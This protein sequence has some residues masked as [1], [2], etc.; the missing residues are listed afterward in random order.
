[1]SPLIERFDGFMSLLVMA[2]LWPVLRRLSKFNSSNPVERRLRGILLAAFVHFLVRIPHLAFNIEQFG[3]LAYATAVWL[4]FQIFLFFET[5]LR[6]HMPLM[7]KIWMVVGSLFWLIASLLGRVD[8]SL[9]AIRFLGIYF[10]ISQGWTLLVCLL[11]RRADY[12]V[13]E[14]RFIDLSMVSLVL[15]GPFLLTDTALA[16]SWGLPRLGAISVLVFTYVS[17]YSDSVLQRKMVT[18]RRLGSS[19]LQALFLA[20]MVSLLFPHLPGDVV[21]RICLVTFAMSLVVKIWNTVN[22]LNGEDPQSRFMSL[23]VESEKS[24]RQ[25]FLRGLVPVIDKIGRKVLT[26]DELKGCDLPAIDRMFDQRQT[27]T[28]SLYE[29][30]E[31]SEEE[32]IQAGLTKEENGAIEQ[33]IHLMET[34]GMNHICRLDRTKTFLVLFDVTAIG[35]SGQIRLQADLVSQMAALVSKAP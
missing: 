15:F 12:N 20:W 31:I 30:R 26:G 21:F 33:M 32:H 3:S 14:N 23:L 7:L 17:I 13:T 28:F 1:M 27:S 25:T 6:R 2:G 22:Y 29:L 8:S 35:Y 4:G 9:E 11:R 5:A 18:F 24:T 19:V 16:Q 34:F 10:L